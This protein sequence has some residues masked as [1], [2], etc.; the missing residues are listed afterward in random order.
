MAEPVRSTLNDWLEMHGL[1]A[2]TCADLLRSRP[3]LPK[4]SDATCQL[5]LTGADVWPLVAHALTTH[6]PDLADKIHETATQTLTNFTPDMEKYPRAFTL[7]D[8]GNGHPY[9]SCPPSGTVRDIL[10]VA[11]EFGHALQITATQDS[12]MP[13]VLRE[14]CAFISE[15]AFLQKLSHTHAEL[16]A[17]ATSHLH[18]QSKRFLGKRLTSLSSVLDTPDTEYDY[19]W[20][21]PPA[22]ILALK[23]ASAPVSDTHY[24]LFRNEVTLKDLL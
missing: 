2:K 8:A 19:N 6:L 3:S 23:L 15:M 24:K 12:E 1:T 18:K 10:T 7:H 4:P 11:H 14:V 21:Y 22:R 5:D 13:P 9:V 16:A 17:A 20:N